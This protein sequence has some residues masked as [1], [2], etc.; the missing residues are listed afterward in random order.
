[1]SVINFPTSQSR[2]CEETPQ[3]TF[4]YTDTPELFPGTPVGLQLIGRTL[5]EEA[6]IGMTEIVDNALKKFRG[7]L[8]G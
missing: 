8:S 6:V 4:E 2:T 5:E 3:L 7:D 1:M